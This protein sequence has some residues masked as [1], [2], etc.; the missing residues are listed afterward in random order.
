MGCSNLGPAATVKV[1]PY[2]PPVPATPNPPYKI[3]STAYGAKAADLV[4]GWNKVSGATHYELQRAVDSLIIYKGPNTK[5]GIVG[6]TPN[7]P[8]TVRVRACNDAGCSAWSQWA[9]LQ[10]ASYHAPTPPPLPDPPYYI[11]KGLKE[12]CPP[13]RELYVFGAALGSLDLNIFAGGSNCPLEVQDATTLFDLSGMTKNR[14]VVLAYYQ[15]CNL[16]QR[17][18]VKFEWYRKRDSKLLYTY[19]YNIPSPPPDY[20]WPWY[21]V[22]SYIGYCDWEINEN[23]DYHV[24][25]T[26][27]AKGTSRT[28]DFLVVGIIP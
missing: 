26:D 9:K 20:Y 25:I 23:G 17:T 5:C 14:E 1:P 6:L 15:P 8:Y 24:K 18:T 21:G 7:S 16:Y 27:S 2:V 19:S 28:I 22:F 10:T 12:P 13:Y 3:S 11:G 4:V